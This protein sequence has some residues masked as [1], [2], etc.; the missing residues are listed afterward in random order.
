MVVIRRRVVVVF[1]VVVVVASVAV[2]VVVVAVAV[3][4][5]VVVVVVA[6]VGATMSHTIVTWEGWNGE[7]PAA[8]PHV[9][10]PVGLE[11]CESLCTA[12]RSWFGKAEMVR[13]IENPKALPR[14]PDL[15]VDMVRILR[16]C[17][18]FV[19]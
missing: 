7:N 9:R 18:T 3:A 4:V 13:T 12:P 1:A 2:V 5:V 19:A 16:P 14:V 6:L 11:W 8:P 10:D 15:S 17:R